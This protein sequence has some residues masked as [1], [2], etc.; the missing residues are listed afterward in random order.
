VGV[1]VAEA[2][3]VAVCRYQLVGALKVLDLEVAL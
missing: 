1:D 3:P 2:D